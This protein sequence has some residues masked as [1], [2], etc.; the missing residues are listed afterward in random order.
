VQPALTR[1]CGIVVA[2]VGANLV[3]GIA[4][5]VAGFAVIGGFR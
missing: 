2:P 1:R 5:A 4:V 3:L